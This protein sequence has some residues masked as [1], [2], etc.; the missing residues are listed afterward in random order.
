MTAR[1]CHDCRFW[2]VAPLDLREVNPTKSFGCVWLIEYI[3]TTT[4]KQKQNNNPQINKKKSTPIVI[5]IYY[6]IK[7]HTALQYRRRFIQ[8]AI[9]ELSAVFTCHTC[10]CCRLASRSR[11]SFVLPWGKSAGCCLLPR[12]RGSMSAKHLFCVRAR[13]ICRVWR[14]QLLVMKGSWCPGVHR[15]VAAEGGLPAGLLDLVIKLQM[16]MFDFRPHRLNGNL[17]FL[18]AAIAGDCKCK[19]PYKARLESLS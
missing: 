6:K 12:T 1:P 3:R 18:T 10:S 11:R 7:G 2:S 14:Y 15:W 16:C 19:C 4:K 8:Q 13:C 5:Y 9:S 17:H